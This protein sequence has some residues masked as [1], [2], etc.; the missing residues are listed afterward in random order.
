MPTDSMSD[1]KDVFCL[2]AC[3]CICVCATHETSSLPWC[4]WCS[5]VLEKPRTLEA[6]TLIFESLIRI[7]LILSHVL[8]F[9]F[10]VESVFAH[11]SQEH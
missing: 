2:P 6:G 10:E 8:L 9:F 3:F 7:Y 5:K 1:H 11:F 4:L